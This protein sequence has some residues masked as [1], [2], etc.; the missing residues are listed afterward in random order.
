MQFKEILKKTWWFIWESDSW[1]SWPV[2][3]LLAFILIKFIVYPG[4]GFIFGTAFPVVAV[5]S[6]SM[7]HDGSFSDWWL[8]SAYCSA[9]CSQEDW[10]AGYGITEEQFKEFSFKNGFNKGDI[11]VLKGVEPKNIKIGDVLVFQSAYGNEP[12]IHRVVAIFGDETTGFVYQ[13]KGDHNGDSGNI[14]KEIQQDAVYGKAIFRIPFLGWIKIA[15]V[16]LFSPFID[17]VFG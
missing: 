16:W 6:G 8:S 9:S 12:I 5:V 14:D 17:L 4:L 11:M 13:T 15:F 2:N 7:E 10:Y 1:W 3:L